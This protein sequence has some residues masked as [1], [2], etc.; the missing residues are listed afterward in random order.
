MLWKMVEVVHDGGVFGV[1]GGCAAVLVNGS[2]TYQDARGGCCSE[3]ASGEP[4]VGM[5]TQR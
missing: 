3:R 4:A 1:E 2:L 5:V